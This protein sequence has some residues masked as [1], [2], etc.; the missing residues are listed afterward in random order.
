MSDSCKSIFVF[1]EFPRLSAAVPLSLLGS[2]LAEQGDSVLVLH[3]A[4]A[5]ME[6]LVVGHKCGGTGGLEGK[7]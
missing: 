5:P 1:G 6:V 3:H 2:R 7:Y 4:G